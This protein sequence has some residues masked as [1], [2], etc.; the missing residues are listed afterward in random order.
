MDPANEDCNVRDV[1]KLEE[2]QIGKTATLPESLRSTRTLHQ[3]QIKSFSEKKIKLNQLRPGAVDSGTTAAGG[4]QGNRPGRPTVSL[5]W[6][7][8]LRP[9]GQ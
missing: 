8:N 4:N 5:T 6:P 7:K 2:Q 3:L 9:M 1:L